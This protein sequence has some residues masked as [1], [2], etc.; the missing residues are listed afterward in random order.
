MFKIA[1]ICQML[2]QPCTR[3]SA[4][5]RKYEFRMCVYRFVKKHQQKSLGHFCCLILY[6]T[7]YSSFKLDLQ[8]SRLHS[9]KCSSQQAVCLLTTILQ[10]TLLHEMKGQKMVIRRLSLIFI[11]LLNS[12]HSIVHYE[13]SCYTCINKSSLQHTIKYLLYKSAPQTDK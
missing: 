1:Q 2:R 6:F 3:N 11:G 7:P 12:S 8:T 4:D 13:T 9:Q 5:Q 10:H